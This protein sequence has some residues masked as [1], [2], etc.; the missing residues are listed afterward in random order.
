MLLQQRRTLKLKSIGKSVFIDADSSLS[1][2][3][4]VVVWDAALLFCKLLDRCG[5]DFSATFWKEKRVLEL[6][7]GTGAVGISVASL[8]GSSVTVSDLP[9]LLPLLQHNVRLN[10]VENIVRVSECRW[11][12][13]QANLLDSP[14][15]DIVILCDCVYLADSLELLVQTIVQ[16]TT[17]IGSVVLFVNERRD[18]ALENRFLNLLQENGRFKREPIS[19]DQLPSKYRQDAE[20]SFW[21]LRLTRS[22]G[23]YDGY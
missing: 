16:R 8:F 2:E 4:G 23:S 10:N 15:Y 14:S 9:A 5:C 11:G 13:S 1:N 7:S 6:G 17:T 21:L 19:I 22:S 3:A 12:S 18:D 20:R